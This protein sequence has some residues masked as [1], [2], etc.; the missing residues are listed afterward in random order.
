MTKFK[1]Y[2]D[3]LIGKGDT[4][5][6]YELTE[7]LD[8]HFEELEAVNPSM[9]WDVIH[10]FHMIVYGPHF[11]EECA[12]YAVSVMQNEDGTMG[13]HWT[14]EETTSVGQQNGISF[15]RFNVWD[16]YYTLNMI[17]SDYVAVI[18]NTPSTYISLAKAWINDK[19]AEEGKAYRYYMAI[20]K[21]GKIKP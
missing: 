18:G 3:Q 8:D 20:P 4:K 11:D 10:E 16:W 7:I 13:Q 17:Y 2:I 15:D 14:I 19:D 9:Y 12:K 21:K 5:Q 1:M 6:M